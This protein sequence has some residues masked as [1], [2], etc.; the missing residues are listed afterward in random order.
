MFKFD[1]YHIDIVVARQDI[2]RV[3][4]T[5]YTLLINRYIIMNN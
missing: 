1:Y 2:S 3:P 5:Y 4:I